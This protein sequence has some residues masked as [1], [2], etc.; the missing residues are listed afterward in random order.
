MNE[1]RH[2]GGRSLTHQVMHELG[3]SIAVGEYGPGNPF[4]IEAELCRRMGVSRS[5]LR[6]AVKMLTAKGMLGSRPRQ[7]TYVEPERVWNLLDPDVL[8]WLLE[9]KFSRE[10]L[11]QFME[12][13]LAIEPMA[14]RLAARAGDTQA[15]DAIAL[16]L[17]RMQAA[18]TGGDDPLDSDIAFHVAIL[19]ASG[20]P[21]Y[22]RLR[23]LIAAA[24]KTSI[25]LTNQAKGVR[26]ASIAE[27]ADVYNAIK[28]GDENEAE[29]AM[30]N[31]IA[32]AM[33]LA[34]TL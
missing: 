3:Q 32:E 2:K 24:L 12:V 25:R 1:V 17:E 30:L 27:H 33:A 31:L 22:A 5:V 14:A 10:L 4:P 9:R 6:E 26:L 7:G 23:D 8:S 15:R 18:E 16:A 29:T 19:Q 11:L 20:N 13:R 21:F 28:A 34:K